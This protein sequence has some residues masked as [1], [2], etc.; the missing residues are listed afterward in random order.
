MFSQLLIT[1]NSVT[2]SLPCVT[3]CAK[4]QQGKCTID[5]H[6]RRSSAKQTKHVSSLQY[7]CKGNQLPLRPT[8][9]EPVDDQVQ[10]EMTGSILRLDAFYLLPSW[11]RKKETTSSVGLVCRRSSHRSSIILSGNERRPL[12]V[13]VHAAQTDTQTDTDTSPGRTRQTVWPT[14]RR[15]NVR[16]RRDSR[17]RSSGRQVVY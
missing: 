5:I 17:R 10:P 8:L 4:E 7:S 3:S 11:T 15:H 16:V 9:P 12:P 13:L 14:G 1:T 6:H 2:D